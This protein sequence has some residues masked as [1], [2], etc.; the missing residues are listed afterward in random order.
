MKSANQAETSSDNPGEIISAH[1]KG[2][3]RRSCGEVEAVVEAM[4]YRLDLPL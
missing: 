3:D 2:K 1:P 4:M